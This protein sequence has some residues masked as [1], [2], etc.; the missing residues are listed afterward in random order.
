[1]TRQLSN[2]R[3]HPDLPAEVASSNSTQTFKTKLKSNLFLVSF[4]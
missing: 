2:P 3:K 1:L 4:P